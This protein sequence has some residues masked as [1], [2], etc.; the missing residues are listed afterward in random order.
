[1]IISGASLKQIAV[2]HLFKQRYGSRIYLLVLE[3]SEQ[4]QKRLLLL[5]VYL[6]KKNKIFIEKGHDILAFIS[7]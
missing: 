1:M 5:A 7:I 6:L 3:F 4:Q 2:F